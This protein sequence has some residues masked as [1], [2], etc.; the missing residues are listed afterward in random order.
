M[1]KYPPI[2]LPEPFCGNGAECMQIWLFGCGLGSR[3]GSAASLMA[4]FPGPARWPTGKASVPGFAEVLAELGDGGVELAGRQA[5]GGEISCRVK[6]A[7][8]AEMSGST[9]RA[10]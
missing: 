6:V 2:C 3:A 8:L 10:R 4:F 1:R 5:T 9:R 7:A